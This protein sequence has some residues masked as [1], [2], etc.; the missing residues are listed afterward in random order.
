MDAESGRPRSVA[1][2]V[3]QDAQDG[4]EHE[5]AADNESGGS[6]TQELQEQQIETDTTWSTRPHSNGRPVNRRPRSRPRCCVSNIGRPDDTASKDSCW[7]RGACVR[8]L[9]PT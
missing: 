8:S 7:A 6:L 3:L 9:H 5:A 2:R 4:D 1:S